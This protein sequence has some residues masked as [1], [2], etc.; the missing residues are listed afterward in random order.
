MGHQYC[1]TQPQRIHH[2]QNA[3]GLIRLAV[4]RACRA[5]RKAEGRQV[6]GDHPKARF[7]QH[8]H[9]V[10]PRAAPA[11]DAGNQQHV[12]AVG[13]AGFLHENADIGGFD[14]IALGGR[15][16][17]HG[18]C[19]AL[20]GVPRENQQKHIAPDDQ[21]QQRKKPPAQQCAKPDQEKVHRAD[22]RAGFKRRVIGCIKSQIKSRS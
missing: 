10:R 22:W 7:S 17:L 3:R 15:S 21:H 2:A 4:E 16:L 1:A 20:L 5:L 14:E 6:Y 18:L 13:R 12:Q 11:A 8:A 19:L 9:G